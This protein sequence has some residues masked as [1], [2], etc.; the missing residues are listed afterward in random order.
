MKE[1]L[2]LYER[3]TMIR[4]GVMGAGRIAKDFCDAAKR[5]DGAEV[6]AIASK[7]LDK[8]KVFAQEKGIAR[9][10]GDYSEMLACKDID[11]IY[12]ATTTNFHYENL[13][14]CMEAGKH[15]LCEKAMVETEARA[16]EVFRLAKEKKLF[17]M[18]AM[19]SMFLP[20]SLKVREWVKAGLVGE[21]TGAQ[22]TIGFSAERDM[23]NRFFNPELGGGA[24]YDLGVYL[25]DLLPYFV[26]QDIVDVECGIQYAP[27]GV[28]AMLNLNLKLEHCYAN[29][30]AQ[31]LAKVPEDCY[32]YG[33]K[34]YI[35]IPKI[36]WGRDCIRYDVDGKEVERFTNDEP[37]GFRFEI[38]ETVRCIES[39]KFESEIAS[40]EMTLI[41]SRIY[42]KMIKKCF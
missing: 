20:K 15:V 6:V 13:L 29:G 3:S 14:Q 21:I 2:V 7:S 42:D 17:V 24:F 11:A 40:H 34:G 1:E 30:Q 32:L 35:Y 23:T 8:A 28:D 36:H 41:S 10:Y 5:A 39:G 37:C 22:A 25:I 38:E 4:F 27:T 16:Q 26:V 33:S 19:W 18:E 31:F 9:A 12:I